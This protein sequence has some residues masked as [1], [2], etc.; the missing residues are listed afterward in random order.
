MKFSSAG[1]QARIITGAEVKGLP[2]MSGE[3]MT[4]SCLKVQW[5]QPAEV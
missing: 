1:T 2:Y 3:I 4:F 5:Y